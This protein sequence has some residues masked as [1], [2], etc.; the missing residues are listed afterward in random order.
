MR[1]P[2]RLLRRAPAR[3]APEEPAHSLIIDFSMSN[4]PDIL[5]HHLSFIFNHGRFEA[6]AM[7][8]EKEADALD[9]Q[10]RDQA[11]R[12]RPLSA[13]EIVLR[14]V[15]VYPVPLE[16]RAHPTGALAML[17]TIFESVEMT[18]QS[19]AATQA[20]AKQA[21]N[22]DAVSDA[23]WQSPHRALSSTASDHTIEVTFNWILSDGTE[24]VDP[25]Y[26]THFKISGP[27][28]Q[29]VETFLGNLSDWLLAESLAEDLGYG[30]LTD[31]SAPYPHA[32]A[33][34]ARLA[35]AMLD[36]SEE[37]EGVVAHAWGQVLEHSAQG[38]PT[39]QPSATVRTR[40]K[41][42]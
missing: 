41:R 19:S 20:L 38:A 5:P 10:L 13:P 11:D 9:A 35:D 6:R 27:Q 7:M 3:R 32:Q 16:D 22:M 1:R 39:F 8:T 40:K 2:W 34:L 23:F 17:E 28:D 29:A 14:Q 30:N 4:T 26:T 33:A 21:Q 12:L 24:G 15:H 36:L 42:P 18:R 37:P 25:P 31:E